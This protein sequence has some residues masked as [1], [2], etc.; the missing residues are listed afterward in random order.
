MRRLVRRHAGEPLAAANGRGKLLAMA[1]AQAGLVVEEIELRRAAVH[2]QVDDSLRPRRMMRRGPCGGGHQLRI[3]Q[4]RQR[5]SADAP[6][7]T[8]EELAPCQA[9]SRGVWRRVVH[10]RVMV[11]S[12]LRS[13]AATIVQ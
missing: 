6:R 12:R 5:G 13:T 3:E 4:R 11:S 1:G 9:E 10:G 7:G 8:A 2:E